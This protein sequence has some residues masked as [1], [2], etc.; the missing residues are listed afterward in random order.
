[1]AKL[2]DS[3]SDDDTFLE[4]LNRGIA[5]GRAKRVATGY[6]RRLAEAGIKPVERTAAAPAVDL[7]P[8]EFLAQSAALRKRRQ[9][10]A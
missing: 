5:A 1:M 10:A 9:R 3:A 6:Y 7:S 4:A 2:H 8:E